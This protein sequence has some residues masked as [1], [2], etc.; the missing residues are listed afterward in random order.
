MSATHVQSVFLVSEQKHS[1]QMDLF[2]D[3]TTLQ[4]EEELLKEDLKKELQ[5][6]KTTIAI[7]KKY[8]KNAI[9]KGMNLEKGA[10]TKIRNKT[11]GGHQA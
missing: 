8:G 4:K 11:I 2:T 6:Q 5:L 3:Y 7:K 9:L 10:T 1:E